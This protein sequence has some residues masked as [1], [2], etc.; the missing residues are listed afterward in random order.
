MIKSARA[1]YRIS[2]TAPPWARKTIALL[3]SRG[4]PRSDLLRLFEIATPTLG[5]KLAGRIDLSM[6]ELNSLAE[7]LKVSVDWLLADDD[8]PP[9]AIVRA[10]QVYDLA[11]LPCDDPTMVDEEFLTKEPTAQE[12]SWLVARVNAEVDPTDKVFP[13]RPVSEDAFA[14]RVRGDLGESE[15]HASD[16]LII[17]GEPRSG[18]RALLQQKPNAIPALGQFVA[19]PKKRQLVTFKSEVMEVTPEPALFGKIVAVVRLEE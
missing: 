12:L 1:T 6:Q 17:D 5:H 7:Y 9:E 19:T 8:L 10:I 15:F 14:I 13:P 4:A 2:R 16:L 18:D 11:C 3:E